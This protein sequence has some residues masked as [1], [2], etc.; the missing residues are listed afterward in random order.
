MGRPRGP[1]IKGRKFKDEVEHAKHWAFLRQKAQANFRQEGWDMTMEEFFEMWRDDL[2]AN[3]GRGADKYCMVRVDVEKP[4]SL[5]NC[6]IIL[7]YQQL[8]RYKNPRRHP[9][10]KFPKL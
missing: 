4:W 3:R 2:W 5:D 9:N 1:F 6:I 8:V 7:R 10:L